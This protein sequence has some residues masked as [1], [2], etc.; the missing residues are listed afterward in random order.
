MSRLER[1]SDTPPNIPN[2]SWKWEKKDIVWITAILE[3]LTGSI[4][5]IVSNQLKPKSYSED[6]LK[7]WKELKQ[8]LIL[9]GSIFIGLFGIT[10]TLY[11]GILKGLF[12]LLKEGSTKIKGI[13]LFSLAIIIISVILG[14]VYTADK[15][16]SKCASRKIEVPP[17]NCPL[18]AT[19]SIGAVDSRFNVPEGYNSSI[20]VAKEDDNVPIVC[21]Y[22]LQNI[23]A[24]FTEQDASTFMSTFAKNNGGYSTLNPEDVYETIM[25]QW[26]ND[27]IINQDNPNGILRT[28]ISDA[29]KKWCSNNN[30]ECCETNEVFMNGSCTLCPTGTIPN[31]NH[32]GCIKQLSVGAIVGIVLG[33]LVGLLLI[34]LAV[35][36]YMKK[37]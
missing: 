32:T 17:G 15:K 37:I 20:P 22:S 9:Y 16:A 25:K 12:N 34:I 30:K 26:C 3:L 23:I 35:L 8:N 2:N 24:N 5:L 19:N 7:A 29:C 18:F 28:K 21:A 36:K 6:D 14:F 31:G 1:Y 33:S 11:T 27:T 13:I 4:L 10:F